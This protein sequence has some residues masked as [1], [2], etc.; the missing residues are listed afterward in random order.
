M[1]SNEDLCNDIREFMLEFRF[2]ED[3]LP[4]FKELSDHGRF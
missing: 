2:P 4:S 1:R 3:H